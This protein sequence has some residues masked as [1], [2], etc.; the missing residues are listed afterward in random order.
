MSAN[1][2]RK[3]VMTTLAGP[4]VEALDMLARERSCSRDALLAQFVLEGLERI[5]GSAGPVRESAGTDGSEHVLTALRELAA[6]LGSGLADIEALCV[7]A[8]DAQHQVARAVLGSLLKEEAGKKRA[9]AFLAGLFE[10]PP[11]STNTM[12]EE[13]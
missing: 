12:T 1:D 9:R 8:L 4:T 13:R 5:S 11:E 6:D 3:R 7:R 10:A 2:E